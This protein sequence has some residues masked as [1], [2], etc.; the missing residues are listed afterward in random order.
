MSIPIFGCMQIFPMVNFYFDCT[1]SKIYKHNN[2]YNKLQVVFKGN[3]SCTPVV[4]VTLSDND[5]NP[6]SCRF[7]S[8]GV[9]F[10]EPYFALSNNYRQ[11]EKV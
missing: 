8:V 2:N 6:E 10:A 3:C 5:K 4:N 7:C 1:K 11:E 9:E